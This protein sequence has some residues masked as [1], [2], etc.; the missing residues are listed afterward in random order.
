MDWMHSK[1]S[2]YW[3]KNTDAIAEAGERLASLDDSERLDAMDYIAVCMARHLRVLPDA[4]IAPAAISCIEDLYATANSIGWWG[5]ELEMY[6]QATASQVFGRLAAK[7]VLL[8]YVVDNQFEDMER[9]IGLFPAFF[10][11]A[12]VVPICPE[13]LA[14]QLPPEQGASARLE[15]A[16]DL[17]RS[18][19][20]LCDR[21]GKHVLYLETDY[22][23]G[24]L[25]ALF[26]RAAR[27]HVLGL[28]RNDAPGPGTNVKVWPA[29][30]LPID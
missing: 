30:A 24:C 25:D 26:T 23:E 16:R 3:D 8:Q 14:Q 18:S 22:E 27:P 28:F 29:D 6:L 2:D 21:E 9:P 5:G 20:A 12:G 13:V 1:I 7:G 15:E 11:A 4:F 17:A 19:V 10:R